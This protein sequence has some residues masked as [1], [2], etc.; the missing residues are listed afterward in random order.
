LLEELQRINARPPL[1]GMGVSM[2]GPTLLEYGT[3]A[4]KLQ[5]LPA[6]ARGEV[7]WCQGYS[8]PGAGSDLASLQTRAD[9]RGDHFLINGS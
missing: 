7:A 4:Q 1:G 2:F 9:D 3:H 5:H 6:I 8:E